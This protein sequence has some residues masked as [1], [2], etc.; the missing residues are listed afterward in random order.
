MSSEPLTTVAEFLAACAAGDRE[1]RA[2]ADAMVCDVVLEQRTHTYEEWGLAGR[3]LRSC[4]GW[5]APDG[6]T[7]PREAPVPY[8]TAG[9]D[10]PERWRLWGEMWEA[11]LARLPRGS[12]TLGWNYGYGY[13]V[14]WHA[15]DGRSVR[16]P[17]GWGP[18]Y[19]GRPT[20]NAA[21]AASLLLAL[22]KLKETDE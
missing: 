7:T 4:P 3:K 13:L 22:D 12:V 16:V 5:L 11:L 9:P 1:L 10:H 6:L 2:E 19:D 20:P 21:L 15:Y 8:A 14:D 18:A 17:E